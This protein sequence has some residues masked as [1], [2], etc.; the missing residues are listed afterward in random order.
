[1]NW[2]LGSAVA[3]E[4]LQKLFTLTLQT[5]VGQLMAELQ[6]SKHMTECV[7][8]SST[9][10]LHSLESVDCNQIYHRLWFCDLFLV[11]A[12]I[13]ALW[14]GKSCV[15]CVMVRLAT[16]YW[17]PQLN[18]TI[19][20]LGEGKKKQKHGR[21]REKQDKVIYRRQMERVVENKWSMQT[22]VPH[23]QREGKAHTEVM[24][25]EKQ[26]ITSVFLWPHTG[27]PSLHADTQL[28]I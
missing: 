26:I 15:D 13:T 25:C 11:K 10:L 22:R 16:C 20:F 17:S 21:K 4:L 6:N 9:V 1:M 8:V 24:Q 28:V 19:Q 7:C 27:K 12:S 14:C 2:W 3:T 5:P 23:I 18:S